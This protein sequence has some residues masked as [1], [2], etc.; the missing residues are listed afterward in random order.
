MLRKVLTLAIAAAGLLGTPVR[1]DD[2]GQIKISKG[3]VTLQRAGQ[4][5]RADPG[6][7]VQGSDVVTTGGDGSV[8]ITM[9]DN[10]LLSAGPNSVLVLDRYEFDSTTNQGRFDASLRRGTLAVVSGR[11]ARQSPDAMTLS[12]PSAILGVRGTEFVVT[13]R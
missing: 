5:L 11:L 3:S 8:G 9:T 10:S 6:A 12:T 2:I 7:R 13:T 1:A 4:T